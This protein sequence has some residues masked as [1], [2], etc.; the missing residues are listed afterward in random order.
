[1]ADPLELLVEI[2]RD[3]KIL[4]LVL[5]TIL[6][7]LSFVKI[8]GKIELIKE[9][10]SNK[11]RVVGAFFLVAGCALL[12]YPNSVAV[13][14]TLRYW[15]G[16]PA[17]GAIIEI[18]G[19]TTTA[20]T[21]GNYKFNNISRAATR[22]IFNFNWSSCQETLNIPVYSL[23]LN[24]SK[25]GER[26]N[27]TI[28]GIVYDEFDK[29]IGNAKVVVTG[30][31]PSGMSSGYRA[32]FTDASGRYVISDVI[33]D[34]KFPMFISVISDNREGPTFRDPLVFSGEETRSGYKLLD[35]YLPSKFTIYVCGEVFEKRRISREAVPNV[36]VEMG[37]RWSDYTDEHGRYCITKVPRNATIYNITD[38]YATISTHLIYPPLKDELTK[39]RNATRNLPI[40]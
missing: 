9:E 26:K 40:L 4:F 21:D 34:P 1:M 2:A 14:G 7:I 18:D 28:S 30:G 37:G 10:D 33:C 5:G 6:I 24:E 17:V 36:L 20:D 32:N 15:D 29:A 38:G 13:F 12:L 31:I 11:A 27:L 25:K 22:I 8:S 23:S 16:T 3:L 39:K 35:I 19:R